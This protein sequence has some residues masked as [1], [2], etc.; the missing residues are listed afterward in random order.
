MSRIIADP[1]ADTCFIHSKS[2]HR[3]LHPIKTCALPNKINAKPMVHVNRNSLK[4][5]LPIRTA[6]TAQEPEDDK[7]I[8]HFT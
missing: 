6:E 3:S 2:F 8:K 5:I 7:Y 1:P 4:T